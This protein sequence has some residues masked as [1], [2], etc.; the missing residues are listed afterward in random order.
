MQFNHFLY[1]DLQKLCEVSIPKDT[2][3][4]K[5]QPSPLATALYRNK[6]K[7]LNSFSLTPIHKEWLVLEQ[8]LLAWRHHTVSAPV[9]PFLQS[10]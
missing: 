1:L 8:S 7:N 4:T 6:G 5:Q 10:E 9:D 2:D 3:I